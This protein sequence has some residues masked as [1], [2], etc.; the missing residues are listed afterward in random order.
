MTTFG[1]PAECGRL[2]VFDS[3]ADLK[4]LYAGGYLAGALPIGGGSNLLFTTGRYDGTV[5]HCKGHSVEF[6]TPDSD[7]I[8]EVRAEAGCILDDLC[9]ASCERGLWG[10]ENL[11]GIPGEIGG[12]AVQN[13]GA[14][15]VEFKDVVISVEAFDC[16]TGAVITRDVTDCLY[17]YRDSVFKH[18]DG[19]NLVV[20]AVK[21]RLATNGKPRLGYAALAALFDGADPTSLAPADL[22]KAVVT[23]RDAKLPDPAKTGSAGSFF[24]NPVITSA[25][26]EKMQEKTDSIM[27][28]H[29]LPNGDVKLSAA[30]LIDHAGCKS[31][32]CGGA[33]VWPNQPLVIANVSGRATGRDVVALEAAIVEAVER[34]F[35]VTLLPEVIH[36]Q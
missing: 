2:I 8:V 24:K 17:G 31:L 1:L 22:R 14:Y 23:L 30:W 35:G 5:L 7:G 28:A 16:A 4:E 36:I 27:P 21:L 15:G 6:G 11:S 20:T 32:S 13:V 12:A 19:K 34:R 9:S 3:V 26:L 29:V 18:P 25:D 10:I 33:S